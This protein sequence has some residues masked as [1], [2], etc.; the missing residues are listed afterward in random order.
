[1]NDSQGLK[2]LFRRFGDLTGWNERRCSACLT[3]HSPEN[4]FN[5]C[6]DCLSALTRR[7]SGYCPRCGEP[8]ARA[9]AP[10]ALCGNCLNQDP[11]WTE[12]R[13][14]GIFEGHL[15]DLLHRGKFAGE[16]ACLDL[17]GKMLA[18]VCM[19]LSRPDAIVPMPLHYKRLKSRGYNQCREIAR[20]LAKALNCPVRDDLLERTRETAPQTGLNRKQRLTNLDAAFIGLPR[21]KGLHVLLLDD[22]STTGTSL[23][24]A[25]LA[26]LKAGSRQVDVAVLAHTSAHGSA[27]PTDFL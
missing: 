5:L 9:E 22:T 8:A 23:R 18:S 3:P 17:L 10:L 15:R 26:L 6:P 2:R 11:P 7:S 27:D 19:D 16:M 12:F 20:P 25:S 13:F 4:D 21:V 1:M 24:Q 14:Y